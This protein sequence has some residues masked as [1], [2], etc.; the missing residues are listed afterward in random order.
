MRAPYFLPAAALLLSGC[1]ALAELDRSLSGRLNPPPA[2]PATVAGPAVPLPDRKPPAPRQTAAAKPAKATTTPPKPEPP[3]AET[4]TAP[5]AVAPV[6]PARTVPATLVGLSADEL[7][8]AMGAPAQEVAEAPGV[9][10]R[11][12]NRVCILDVHLFP[13]VESQGL[14]AL[15]VSATGLPV[16]ACL[17]SFRNPP[18]AQPAAAAESAT[19]A[20]NAA[21]RAQ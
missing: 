7:R 17:D 20:E 3:P 12:P 9:R 8:A 5:V 21:P 11:Y 18:P 4:V 1:T 15:D 6:P 13:R 19:A 10:W 2:A 16:E 14:Y